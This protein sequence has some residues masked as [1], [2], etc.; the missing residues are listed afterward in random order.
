MSGQQ[1]TLCE[2]IMVLDFIEEATADYLCHDG[3]DAQLLFETQQDSVNKAVKQYKSH[4]G[5]SVLISN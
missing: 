3:K 2:A 1:Y 5:F 4:G